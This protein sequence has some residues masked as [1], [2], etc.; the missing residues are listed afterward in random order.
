MLALND[1]SDNVPSRLLVTTVL[2]SLEKTGSAK[3]RPQAIGNGLDAARSTRF[4]IGSP[5]LLIAAPGI[6]SS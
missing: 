4:R 2:L 3:M 5:F 6:G 1:R